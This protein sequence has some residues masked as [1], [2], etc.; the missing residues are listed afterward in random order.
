[1]I[2]RRPGV[3]RG[4]F[5]CEPPTCF[6]PRTFPLGLLFLRFLRNGQSDSY[7]RSPP[8]NGHSMSFQ[9]FSEVKTVNERG[10]V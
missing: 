7:G 5:S 6:S 3:S 1:M 10:M 2:A 8:W 9:T 4:R